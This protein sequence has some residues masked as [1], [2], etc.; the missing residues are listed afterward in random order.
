MKRCIFIYA[1]DENGHRCPSLVLEA[2]PSFLC[3]A[4]LALYLLEL[5]HVASVTCTS[6][7]VCRRHIL[8]GSSVQIL[9][10]YY[11]NTLLALS[12]AVEARKAAELMI[13]LLHHSLH[14]VAQLS[15]NQISFT[16]GGLNCDVAH[17]NLLMLE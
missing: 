14:V 10:R 6:L 11:L 15:A 2:Q 13:M 3:L 16:V 4:S 8:A 5:A 17:L 9:S 12:S 1:L 7:H